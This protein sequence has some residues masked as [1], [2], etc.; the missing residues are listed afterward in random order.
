MSIF[1]QTFKPEVKK[2]LEIRQDAILD[3][4]PKS[5][6]YYNSRNAWIR[7]TSAVDVGDDNAALAK[8]Y[9][10]Q[11]GIL[12]SSG[13]LRSGLGPDGSYSNVSPNGQKYGYAT[14][15]RPLTAGTAGIRPMP[16]ITSI[17]IKSKAAYGSLREVTVH[18]NAWD[19]HQ[20]EDLE[21]LYMRPG[22]SVLVEWGW[23]PYLD[24]NGNLAISIDTTDILNGKKTK[25]EI[26]KEIFDKSS[27]T[28]NYEGIYGF[29]KNY[30]WS[31][32]TDGGYDCNVTVITMGEVLESL[33]INYNSANT[34]TNKDGIFKTAVGDK[35]NYS[36]TDSFSA[37]S[38]ISTSVTKAYSEN[39][40]AGIC[41]EL[42]GI[43]TESSNQIDSNYTEKQFN[44]YTFFR[45]DVNVD[46]A[47]KNAVFNNDNHQIY[48]TLKDFCD[49]LNK[50]VL[51]HDSEHKTPIVEISVNEGNH[52]NGKDKPLLCLAHPLQMS[53]DPTICLIKNG[54][55]SD[56]ATLGLEGN[57]DTLK[58]LMTGLKQDYW[59]NNNYTDT[60]LGVIGNI[61]VNL[62]YIYSLVTNK[63]LATQ[64]K[65]EKNEVALFDFLKN[66]LNGISTSIGNVATL[67]L[68]VDPVD[69]IA[70]IID[71]NYADSEKRSKVYD[72][73]V[74]LEMQNLKSTVRSYSLQSQ[75][76][77]EQSTMV[78]IGAQTQGGALASNVNTLIDFNQNLIDR[79][80]PKKD[81]PLVPQY[82]NLE[83]E[84]NE[85][86]ANIGKNITVLVS[87]VNELEEGWFTDSS[88]NSSNASKYDN[89]LKDIIN[90]YRALVKDDSKNRDIIPTKLSIEMDG[91][92][93]LIIGN[94]FKIPDDLLP[95]GYKGDGAGPRKIAYVVTG[96]GHT[97]QNNDWITKIESQFI[98][99]DE[100]RGLALSVVDVI[101]LINK[102]VKENT[103]VARDVIAATL[104]K[105]AEG[106]SRL[107]NGVIRKNGEIDDILVR[108]R[109]DLETKYKG[110]VQSD[111]GKI[112][113]QAA[114]MQSLEK[115]LTAASNA[116]VNLKVNSA[117]RTYPDQ[118]R[119]KAQSFLN[120]YSPP[121]AEP[122]TSNHGFGLAVD[123][124]DINGKR[125]S[126]AGT[127]VEWQWIQKWKSYYNFANILNRKTGE[128][129][130]NET[131]HYNF[132]G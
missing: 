21:L 52:M 77:P 86:L 122:G 16:G 73:I 87:Y 101:K 4:K 10:L 28:A 20:L 93:G 103:N 94:L 100:P 38:T 9:I 105:A 46:A 41:T 14:D 113:L 114:A 128:I 102:S 112:R 65:K 6:Q 95:R 12:N 40:I 13:K 124:A 50:Y 96:L 55:W 61:Y 125:L 63:A 59:Y 99:L 25:E 11:G 68:F 22:Y 117:Y 51:L 84:I 49:I 107:I 27:T 121:A 23:S 69:S 47:N 98:I 18:F 81:S 5:L 106:D 2:Q 110:I 88:F 60:Q 58:K 126:P 71:I 127:P 92:G 30:G 1:K 17:D 48:I 120:V 66:M 62:G 116:G 26:W 67:D 64:D 131:H 115:M 33:K 31:A 83:D 53:T 44:G 56:P 108:M 90:F 36:N 70:R 97:V 129:R 37:I 104:N 15:G 132:I 118:V 7:M 39:I 78:A 29:I 80:I 42:Y 76:F 8:K 3:R 45:F 19:I 57:F 79:I 111:G 130:A 72:E 123:L 91:I 34:K 119:V 85:K 75:I 89:A 54:V 82:D 24:N 43:M 35:K 32:R 74:T 109:L